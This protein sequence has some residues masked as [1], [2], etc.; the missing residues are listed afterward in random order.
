VKAAALPV[1]EFAPTLRPKPAR[2]RYRQNC[3]R[4]AKIY[5]Q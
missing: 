2:R 1:T 3:F 4:V 5:S